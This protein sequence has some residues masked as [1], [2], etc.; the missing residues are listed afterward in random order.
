MEKIDNAPWIRW[1]ERKPEDGQPIIALFRDRERGDR[2]C[3]IAHFGSAVVSMT[4]SGTYWGK[5]L[6]DI[7]WLELPK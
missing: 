1:S 7:Y 2:A 4:E 3:Q 6:D 5:Y